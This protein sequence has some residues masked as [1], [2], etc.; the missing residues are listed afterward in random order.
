MY[1]IKKKKLDI[2]ITHTTRKIGAFKNMW[3]IIYTIRKKKKKKKIKGRI[4]L[5][6]LALYMFLVITTL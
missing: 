6:M 4:P 1:K 3:F 5:T 2:T